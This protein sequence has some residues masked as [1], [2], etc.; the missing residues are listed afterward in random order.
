MNG[1]P[2][3]TVNRQLTMEA[4]VPAQSMEVTAGRVSEE[5][6]SGEPLAGSS[7][8]PDG[9]PTEFRGQARGLRGEEV[10]D[11]NPRVPVTQGYEVPWLG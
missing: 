1:F 9:S 7:A 3:W 5:R 10:W 4:H 6:S 2:S 8:S 11:R